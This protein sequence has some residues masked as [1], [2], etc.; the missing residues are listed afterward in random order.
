MVIDPER[1]FRSEHACRAVVGLI[2]DVHPGR[3]YANSTRPYTHVLV[4]LN[5][6]GTLQILCNVKEGELDIAIAMSNPTRWSDWL[7]KGPF[8]FVIRNR[9]MVVGFPIMTEDDEIRIK[10]YIYNPDD[11][12]AI[13]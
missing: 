5:T 8:G 13:R 11:F 10:S 9:K 1:V 2:F 3:I 12:I 7:E 4:P 6:G